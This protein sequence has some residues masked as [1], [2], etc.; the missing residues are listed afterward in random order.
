M[1]EAFGFAFRQKSSQCSPRQ[2]R[3][4]NFTRQFS[5]DI[6]HIAGRDNMIADTLSRI[7]ELEATIDFEALAT[8]QR[9]DDELRKIQ[10]HSESASRIK[11]IQIPGTNAAVFC[12]VSTPTAR[13]F[14]TRPF[15]KGV[16]DSLHRLSHPGTNATVKLVTHL[17]VWPSI[18]SDCRKWAR[19]CLECQQSKVSSP[20][21]R[22][23]H[24]SNYHACFR[25][26]HVLSHHD[27]PLQSMLRDHTDL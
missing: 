8:S 24:R 19:N 14:V 6:C 27:R 15:R 11:R 3:Y 20:S 21:S 22:F 1:V 2:F 23:D 10:Q 16:F 9:S 12:D 26:A 18:N 13:P 25:A 5:T 7:E 4:L 17:Y